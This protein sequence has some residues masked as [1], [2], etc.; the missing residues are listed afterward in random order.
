MVD[1]VCLPLFGRW[2]DAGN[3]SR[4]VVS[5][6]ARYLVAVLGSNRGLGWGKELLPS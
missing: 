4:Q 1:A 6:R 2:I 5:S 3:F